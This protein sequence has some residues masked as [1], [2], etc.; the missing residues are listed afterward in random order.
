MLVPLLLHQCLLRIYNN[1][2]I[3]MMI[4]RVTNIPMAA[5]DPPERPDDIC[6]WGP[7]LGVSGGVLTVGM[8]VS[9]VVDVSMLLVAGDMVMLLVVTEVLVCVATLMDVGITEV[10]V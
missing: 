10:L 8:V 4:A 5:L 9:S 7:S 6:I 1:V 3:A 2:P